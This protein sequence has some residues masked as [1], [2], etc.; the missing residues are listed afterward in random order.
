[1]IRHSDRI[2]LQKIVRGHPLGQM[3]FDQ[4]KKTLNKGAREKF[5]S[6]GRRQFELKKEVL[7]CVNLLLNLKK[8][9]S[10]SRLLASLSRFLQS[11]KRKTNVFA[12]LANI[13]KKQSR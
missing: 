1:M 3:T 7:L 8:I 9:V 5:C 12:V 6:D 11:T 2:E 4:T 13:E 10:V